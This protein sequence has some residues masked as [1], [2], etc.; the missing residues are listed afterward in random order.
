MKMMA[1]ALASTHNISEED[2]EKFLKVLCDVIIDALRL[3]GQVKIK[4][5]GTFKLISAPEREMIDVNS[6]ERITVEARNRISF[7]PDSV[8]RDIINKPFIFFDTV[9]L[10]D[11]VV[12]DDEADTDESEDEEDVDV[13]DSHQEESVDTEDTSE[14]NESE[15]VVVS[16]D[17]NKVMEEDS[18]I[19]ESLE[20]VK[21]EEESSI[22]ESS[23]DIKIEEESSTDESPKEDNTTEESSDKDNTEESNKDENIEDAPTQDETPSAV[24]E[25]LKDARNVIDEIQ[26]GNINDDDSS[27]TL[28]SEEKGSNILWIIFLVLTVL[29]AAGGI[30][31]GTFG[32]ECFKIFKGTRNTTDSTFV[33]TTKV[34]NDSIVTDSLKSDSVKVDSVRTDS[35]TKVTAKETNVIDPDFYDALDVRIRTGAYR[36]VGV[37]KTV[38]VEKGQTF[39]SITKAYLGEGMECY[40]EAL[41]GVKSVQS[42]DTLKIPKLEWRKKRKK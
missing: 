3:E 2:A 6:G 25:A 10:H 26:S 27:N 35:V 23:E 4:G 42:G 1:S 29:I 36:I 7:S 28:Y 13:D 31:Y 18:Y 14:D 17:D 38:K 19:E 39:N 15:D 9:V 24:N 8:L 34:H 33:D 11:G 41:N 12:F 22:E 20:D 30:L 37:Y 21:I 40:M 5:L 32:D 16:S